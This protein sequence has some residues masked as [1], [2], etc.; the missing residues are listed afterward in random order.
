MNMPVDL[1]W[2]WLFMTVTFLSIIGAHII[3]V[4]LLS[5]TKLSLNTVLDIV[6]S[7]VPNAYNADYLPEQEL[8]ENMLDEINA[9]DND[10]KF[11][12]APSTLTT[13][14]FKVIPE[15]VL[16]FDPPSIVMAPPDFA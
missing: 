5:F 11:K 2:A 3:H 13:F 14:L 7:I 16:D 1:I 9:Y 6:L 8:D 15:K 10:I 4:E 12:H